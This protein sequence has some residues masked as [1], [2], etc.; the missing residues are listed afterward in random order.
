MKLKL[1]IFTLL[2]FVFLL[3][4]C[5]PKEY[6][7]TFVDWD[8]T[9]LEEKIYKEGEEILPPTTPTREGYVF[10][11][12]NE[13]YTV[14]N[15]NA[16]IKATYEVSK[17]VVT[18]I[19]YNNEL[20]KEE[21]VNHN[22]SA[23]APTV[24]P[25]VGYLFTGWDKEFNLITSDLEV[26]AN[27]TETTYTVRFYDDLENLIKEETV[28]HGSSAS[29][30]TMQD[31]GD[32]EFSNWDKQFTNVTGDLDV[33]A[34]YKEKEYKIEFYDGTNKLTLDV[35]TYKTSEEISLPTPTKTGHY[36]SGWFLSEI[37]LYEVTT[38]DGTITGDLKLYARWVK[39]EKNEFVEPTNTGEFTK[40][41]RN[42]HSNGVSYVYQPQFPAGTATTS[43][44]A[45][46][47]ASTNTKVATISAYS[48]ISIAS[49]GY[50]I[51]T[52]T[53]KSNSTIVYYCVIQTSADGVVKSTIEE[54]NSPSYATVRFK[55]SDTNIVEKIVSKGGFAIAPTPLEKSGYTFTGWVGENNESIYNITKDTTFIPTYELGSKSY[56]GKTISVLGDS[57]TTYAGYIP[58]GFAHFYPYPTA[59]LADVNQTWWMQFINHYGMKLLANNSWSGSAVAGDAQSAAQKLSRLDHLYIGEVK[60]DVILIFM[61]AN[62]AGS[63]YISLNMFDEAYN[64][65]IENI[66]A[67]S[68]SSEIILCTLPAI[69][70]I[71]EADQASYNAVINKYATSNGLTVFNFENAFLRSEV[72]NYLVDS[73]HPNKAGMDKLAQVA[74]SDFWNVVK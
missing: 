38:L 67:V 3:V 56:A 61:G 52:A 7:V 51:I 55:L 47:W 65:M 40:I 64:I 45:Y 16:T 69:T 28:K 19:G 48:S 11:G 18:F 36:F 63:P 24:T 54:A 26:I 44:T 5:Q 66:K 68:P 62:D 73:A 32:E 74:I 15:K 8:D 59:D 39:L 41:N 12:W 31:R 71:G 4:G 33:Y 29:A 34:I 20:L 42:L 10:S 37:S 27:F 35:S 57:I 58:N 2:S 46:D 9:V 30:P 21:T 53:L 60:P 17:W 1:I 70:M 23:T 50:A 22:S 13:E 72:T 14:A 6:T 43:V 25:P 49:P